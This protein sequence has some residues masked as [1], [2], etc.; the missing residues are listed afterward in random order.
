M[1]VILNPQPSLVGKCNICGKHTQ[2]YYTDKALYRESLFC[3]ECLSTSRYRSIAR[4]I[5]KAI[6][7]CTGVRSE[8]IAELTPDFRELFLRIYDTQVPFKFSTCAYPI[9][10]L[11]AKCRWID[12]QTSIYKSGVPWGIK[13]GTNITNQNLEKLTFPDNTFDMVVTS[14]VMEHV[15]LD[16]MAH[17]EIQRVLK[18]GGIYLFTVPHIRG[19]STFVRVYVTDPADPSKD[20]FLEEPEYHGDANSKEGQTLSFRVYGKDLDKFLESLGFSVEYCKKDFPEIGIMDT[21]LF[22]CKLFK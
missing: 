5:L 19:R 6:S 2:F 14:D 16:E 13:Q 3:S 7:E 20:K 15:R 11:L 8:S 12:V 9:P 21:E 1:E 4:G 18:P 22:Y 17:K 10:D